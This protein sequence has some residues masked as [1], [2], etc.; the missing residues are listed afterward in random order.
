[1]AAFLLPT[2]GTFA[3]KIIHAMWLYKSK[4]PCSLPQRI[5]AALAGMA[6]THTIACAVFKAL[7]TSN[8]PFLR[9]PKAEN[10]PA[11]IKGVLMAR[12]ELLILIALWMA[13]MGVAWRYDLHNPE[14]FLW[15]AVLVILSLPYVAAL[16]CSLM[17]VIPP[18]KSA[19]VTSPASAPPPQSPEIPQQREAA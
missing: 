14:A 9:T 2:L 4:V 11:F 6:L 12:E 10:K 18:Q 13:C 16:I 3:F 15:A 7:F 5:A 17:S 8:Q 19:C 1:M